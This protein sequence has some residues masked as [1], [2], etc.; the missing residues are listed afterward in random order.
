MQI[1]YQ[2]EFKKVKNWMSVTV[3]VYIRNGSEALLRLGALM[4]KHMEVED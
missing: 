3:E 2:G 1:K 4:K